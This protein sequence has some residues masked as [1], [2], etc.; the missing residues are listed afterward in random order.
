[1]RDSTVE[2]AT[3]VGLWAEAGLN[4]SGSTVRAADGDIDVIGAAAA[5]VG[6]GTLPTGGSIEI[7]GSTFEALDGNLADGSDKGELTFL[8]QFAPI[9][10]TDNVR[11]R[12]HGD[13]AI[14]TQQS[15]IGEGGITLAGNGDVRAGVFK[16]EDAV[17]FRPATI[18]EVAVVS[19]GG[20]PGFLAARH[21]TLT[22]GDGENTG[23]LQLAAGATGQLKLEDNV[24]SA[25]GGI[26]VG[27]PDLLGTT[28]VLTDNVFS[29]IGDAA[30]QV[31][32]QLI[33]GSCELSGNTFEA[34]DIGANDAASVNLACEGANPLEDTFRVEGNTM[35]AGGDGTSVLLTSFASGALTM[36]SNQVAV[37]SGFLIAADDVDGVVSSNIIQLL[38]GFFGVIGNAASD[39]TIDANVVTLQDAANYGL[40][41]GGSGVATVTGNNFTVTGTPAATATAFGI[42]TNSAPIE[43]TASGNTFTNFSRALYIS[44]ASGTAWGITAAIHNNVFDFVINAAPKVATLFN[45]KSSIDA[46]NNQWGTNTSSATVAGYVTLT[47]DTA[48]QGGSIQLNPITQP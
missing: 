4:V 26:V 12:S 24:L 3:A 48:V 29:A 5:I 46:R 28:A 27:A 44:D 43:V 42:G 37:E 6:S 17:H 7:A 8:T 15:L 35:K 31:I 10:L 19:G 14:V 1:M 23:V 2:S 47:G 45:V 30:P 13:M 11:I 9:G 36:S 40:L 22:A 34:R 33:G 16:S 20:T 25:D 21:N 39:M 32:T 41:M 18:D 38:G